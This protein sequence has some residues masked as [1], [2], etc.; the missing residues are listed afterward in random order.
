M[1]AIAL[2]LGAGIWAMTSLFGQQADPGRSEAMQ[3][4][5]PVTRVPRSGQT[6]IPRAYPTKTRP[7]PAA[8]PSRP[9]VSPEDYWLVR[10]HAEATLNREGQ[11]ARRELAERQA[12]WLNVLADEAERDGNPE[13][14]RLMRAR[15]TYLESVANEQ[16]PP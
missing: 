3:T 11:E 14:A 7:S 10:Q 9:P 12:A 13:R 8:P 6:S 15:V 2:A 4:P 16:D 1:A 5:A